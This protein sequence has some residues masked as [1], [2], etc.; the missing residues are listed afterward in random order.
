[1]PSP[2]SAAPPDDSR[3]AD[4]RRP[5][6]GRARTTTRVL[7]ALVEAASGASSSRSPPPGPSSDCPRSSRA[8]V[9]TPTSAWAPSRTR[10]S[11]EPRSA[12][13]RTTSSPRSPTRDWSRS[14]HGC[15]AC[16]SCRAA[17]RRPSC[18]PRGAP[19]P[20]RSRCSPP[21]QVTAGYLKDLRGP[22]PG[23]EVVPSRRH[24][25]RRGRGLAAA[26]EQ[27]QSASADLSSATPS[28]VATWMLSASG[29]PPSS[30]PARRTAPR[31]RTVSGAARRH[32]RRDDGTL[33]HAPRSAHSVTPPIS[34]SA[35]GER[36]A[37]SRSA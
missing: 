17:S 8:S 31:E 35:S 2:G 6:P 11:C 5:R 28:A 23:I 22:F 34:R 3:A 10:R 26:P 24:R 18:T 19:A 13:A 27:P 12:R 29:P 21:S 20:R 32:D 1:M 9:R 4:R 25:S 36:R 14:R 7:A 33:P 16:R 37:T 15:S 30:T